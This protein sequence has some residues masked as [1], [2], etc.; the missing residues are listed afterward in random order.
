VK[1]H[2]GVRNADDLISWLR[3]APQPPQACYVVH[4][5][6]ASS[7]ALAA[8]I[9]SELDWCVVAPRPGERVLVD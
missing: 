5:E 7:T 9:R 3:C 2:G 8:R 4:G 1:I 6:E